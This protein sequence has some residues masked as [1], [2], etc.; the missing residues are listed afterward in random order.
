ME[1][2]VVSLA[3]APLCMESSIQECRDDQIWPDDEE[4]PSVM[5]T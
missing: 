5:K 2:D 1:V 4:G 3:P